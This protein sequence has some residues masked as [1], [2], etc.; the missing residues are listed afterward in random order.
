LPFVQHDEEFRMM[1]RA[2]LALT[3][4]FSVACFDDYSTSVGTIT[5]AYTL[6]TINGAALPYTINVNATTRKEIIDDIITLF[7]GGTYSRTQHANTTVSGQ[8]TSETTT[9]SGPYQLLGT[10]VTLTPSG[11]GPTTITTIDGRTMTIVESGITWTF[12]K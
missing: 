3:L 5:G 8:T 1:V 9:E 10:S 6:R 11:G 2:L 4:V 7:S 12:M